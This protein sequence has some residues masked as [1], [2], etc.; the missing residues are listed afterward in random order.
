MKKNQLFNVFL[1][2]AL[3][4]MIALTAQS[5]IETTRVALAAGDSAQVNSSVAAPLCD[6]PAVETIH[7]VYV[8]QMNTWMTY[9]ES[10][11]TGIDGGLIEL[12]SGSQ[13]CTP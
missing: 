12:L 5:A 3:A 13:T 10:G 7:S 9:T 1:I 6:L 8:E 2:A 11:P 4:L